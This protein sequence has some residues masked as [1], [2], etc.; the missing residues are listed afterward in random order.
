MGF[1]QGTRGVIGTLLSTGGWSVL[2]AFSTLIYVK[3]FLR[4][5]RTANNGWSFGLCEETTVVSGSP[6]LIAVIER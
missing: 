2:N 3:V 4:H 5:R 1:L 6:S